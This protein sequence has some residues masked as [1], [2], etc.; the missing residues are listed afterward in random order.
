MKASLLFTLVSVSVLLLF[1]L[2]F[3]YTPIVKAKYAEFDLLLWCTLGDKNATF[4]DRIDQGQIDILVIGMGEFFANN[5][6]ICWTTPAGFDIWKAEVLA[7]NP[8]MKF[9]ADLYSF[10]EAC[11]QTTAEE[12]EKMIVEINTFI[13]DF[14]TRFD[15]IVDDTEV[16]EGTIDNHLTYFAEVDANISKPY[17]PWLYYGWRSLA[18][19]ELSAVGLY[20][21]ESYNE[22]QW[23]DALDY[24]RNESV[25]YTGYSISIWCDGPPPTGPT[26]EEQL[27]FLD[28][29]IALHGISYFNK[30]ESFG[31]WWYSG[32]T[33]ADWTAWIN[34]AGDVWSLSL[35]V[36]APGGS[37]TSGNVPVSLTATGNDT[38]SGYNW[39]IWTG[40]TWLYGT[41]HTG[42]IS[43][44]AISQN[45]TYTFCGSVTG[46]HGAYDYEENEFIVYYIT[47]PPVTPSNEPDIEP[48]GNFNIMP[49]AL[50]LGIIGTFGLMFMKWK[51]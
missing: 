6:L 4:L 48:S 1:S 38:V 32:M 12:R 28:E 26:L 24:V 35:N 40:T 17:Y 49:I 8:A 10:T 5:S 16:Y 41:N 7:V 39:N 19:N 25:A 9:Y 21:A 36:W 18:T 3:L 22:T 29:E 34:W 43:T 42:A 14:G 23:K 46:V 47:E 37:Y 15:A 51:R 31:V 45:G 33:A 2:A 11:N 30:M 44:L 20:G 50:P 13:T 27:D